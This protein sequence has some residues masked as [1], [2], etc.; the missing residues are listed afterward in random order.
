MEQQLNMKKISKIVKP[1]FSM[2]GRKSSPEVHSG[3]LHCTAADR[4]ECSPEVLAG[5][6]HGITTDHETKNLKL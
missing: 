3:Y 2:P 6:L 1:I 4:G 5:N